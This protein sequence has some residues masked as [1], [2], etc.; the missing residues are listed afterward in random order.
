MDGEFTIR[1]LNIVALGSGSFGGIEAYLYRYYQNIDRNAVCFDFAFCGSNTMQLVMEDPIF[2]SSMFFELHALSSG[3]NSI[4]N[5]I[6]LLSRIRELLRTGHYN[7]V[8]VHSASPMINAVC[9]FATLP[10]KSIVH[11]SHAHALVMEKPEGIK[12][13]IISILKTFNA[14]TSDYLFA[15]SKEAGYGLFGERF[16][17]SEKFVKAYNAID[18]NAFRYNRQKRAEFRRRH[19]IDDGTLLV[20]H[21]ARLAEEKNQLFLVEVFKNIHRA[22]PNSKLWI[23]G[24]G[25]FRAELEKRILDCGASD[26]ISLLGEAK[27]ICNYL[28]AM[29]LFIITSYSEGLCISAI[30]SQASGLPTY[31]SN[32]VPEE[33]RI[34]DLFFKLSLNDNAATWCKDILESYSVVARKDTY[35]MIVKNGY[36]IK[37]AA[38]TMQGFY[39]THMSLRPSQA[40]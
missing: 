10:Y 7:Y 9:R 33:C 15:C 22:I 5:W 35:D 14:K 3:T 12:A 21:V 30:E 28:Q 38:T 24:E 25:E 13:G 6:A 36:D 26:C 16:T 40:E 17:E 34:T 39:Q 4:A 8:H 29:D 32:G 27:D 1:V 31:V 20:G 19:D 2:K 18:A 37:N 23:I 11:I